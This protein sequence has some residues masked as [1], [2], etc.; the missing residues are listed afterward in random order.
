MHYKSQSPFLH[1][2]PLCVLL[3]PLPCHPLASAP[4][5]TSCNS[6]PQKTILPLHTQKNTQ[7]PPKWAKLN[8]TLSPSIGQAGRQVPHC[9]KLSSLTI[10]SG[11]QRGMQTLMGCSHC[12]T[13][14]T[15]PE[16]PGHAGGC[17]WVFPRPTFAHPEMEAAAQPTPPREPRHTEVSP[18]I[19][20]GN[21]T[22]QQVHEQRVCSTVFP[23]ALV[24]RDVPLPLQQ[25]S[26]QSPRP[27][28]EKQSRA[29]CVVSAPF[30][31]SGSVPLP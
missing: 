27:T 13:S 20:E 2:L 14:P 6:C 10:S 25:H 9:G 23:A 7:T 18:L 16:D 29:D 31:G 1:G 8:K 3:S 26:L 19:E 28:Q 30:C 24:L 11:V 5:P 17:N 4:R 21:H 12:Q 22:S 15:A